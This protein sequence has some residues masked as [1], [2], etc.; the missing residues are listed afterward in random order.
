L[1]YLNYWILSFIFCGFIGTSY[2]A[3]SDPPVL[4]SI[5]V[6]KTVV[7]V[8]QGSQVLTFS[9]DITDQSGISW[10]A[11]R[12]DTNIVLENP[13]SGYAYA[14]GTNEEP[15]KL[16]V[17]FDNADA[18]V[19][20]ILWLEVKDIYNNEL[21]IRVNALQEF[22]LPTYV[23]VIGEN[24]DLDFDFDKNSTLDALTDG[25]LLLRYT[26]GL[27]GENLTNSAISSESTLTPE[28]VEANVEQA[29][30]IAD[31][32]NNSSLDALTDG[33]LFLRYAFGLRGDSLVNNAV[34]S[35]ATRTSAED[36][37]AYIESHTP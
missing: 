19:W 8:T 11:G 6:D 20:S 28:E 31:I 23:V 17:T 3:E 1:K 5:S 27:R 29:A 4:N 25:L 22:G 9:L 7:D 12:N 18:G 15:G 32:D 34:A 36:I 2:A 13:N 30:S 14:I 21:F 37:E 33:L 24:F 16:K 26:F 10:A 35:S